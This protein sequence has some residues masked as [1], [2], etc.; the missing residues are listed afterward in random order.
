[1][2][3]SAD[4]TNAFFFDGSD[5]DFTADRTLTEVLTDPLSFMKYDASEPRGQLFAE[6]TY[7]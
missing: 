6:G 2:V 4:E 1:M 5:T 3:S 7:A